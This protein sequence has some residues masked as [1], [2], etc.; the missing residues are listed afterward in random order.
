MKPKWTIGVATVPYRAAKLQR[1][2]NRL[3]PQVERAKGQ[4]EVLVFYNNMEHKIGYFRQKIMDEAQGEYISFI[5]DDDLVVANFCDAI[6]PLLDGVDYIGFNVEL[7]NDGKTLKPV[8]HTLKYSKWGEDDQGFYR[9]VTHLNPLRT[10][11]AR[12]SHFPEEVE[13]G[14]DYTWGC[15][16]HTYMAEHDREF[17]EHY[18]DRNMY[19][20]D[21]YGHEEIGRT[22]PSRI[23]KPQFSSKYVR[24]HP[25][26]TSDGTSNL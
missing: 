4:I 23:R 15:G 2:M 20:Y 26:S 14:E 16:V 1:M 3:L 24:Y 7:R 8:Y 18:I 17:T 13:N 12:K 22:P 25:E 9:G 21:H 10:K 5:D 6:L 11:L 19:L